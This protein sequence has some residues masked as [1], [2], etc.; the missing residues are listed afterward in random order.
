MLQ[1]RTHASR[2]NPKQTIY[3]EAEDEDDSSSEDDGSGDASTLSS[4]SSDST[5]SRNA[6]LLFQ[7]TSGTPFTAGSTRHPTTLSLASTFSSDALA[8]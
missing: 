8:L 5:A 3:C 6:S 7:K 1:K 2:T 4:D